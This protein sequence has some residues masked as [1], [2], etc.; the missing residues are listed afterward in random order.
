MLN[1]WPPAGG[2]ILGEAVEAVRGET[3][4]VERVGHWGH[5]VPHSLLSPA[6]FPS[7]LMKPLYHIPHGYELLPSPGQ[8]LCAKILETVS[9]AQPNQPFLFCV[10]SLR[11]FDQGTINTI[12]ATS[13]L[14]GILIS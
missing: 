6:S 1:I 5:L 9:H 12:K 13:N 7:A 4:E 2:I 8:Q 14:K 10:S 3:K 11:R